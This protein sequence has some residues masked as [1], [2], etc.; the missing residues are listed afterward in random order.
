MISHNTRTVTFAVFH[1]LHAKY[2]RRSESGRK[3]SSGKCQVEGVTI[4]TQ[5]LGSRGTGNMAV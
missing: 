1:I 4:K 3:K 2:E 5:T